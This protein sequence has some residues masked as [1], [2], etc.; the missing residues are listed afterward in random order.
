M[1]ARGAS[2]SA[3]AELVFTGFCSAENSYDA[4]STPK[5]AHGLAKETTALCSGQNLAIK[6]ASQPSQ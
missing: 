5:K 6:Y 2:V 1:C 4:A 3:A